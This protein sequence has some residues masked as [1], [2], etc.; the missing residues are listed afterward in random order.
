MR[1][2]VYPHT[3]EVGGSQLN[4]IELAEAVR[5]LG[6]EVMLV[7]DPGP[8]VERVKAAG[9]EHVELDTARRRPDPATV[10]L[11]R[12]LVA[13]RGID[14]VHGYEWP[15][16]LEAY[17]ATFGRS[18]AAAVCTVMSSGV[19]PFLPRELPLIVGTEE[20]RAREAARRDDVRLIEPPVDVVANAP[21]HPSEEFRKRFGLGDDRLDI[22]VVCRLVPEL[23]LEG[24]LTAVEVVGRL[25]AELPVRL[26]VVGDGAARDQ[27]ESRAAEANAR[28]GERVVVLTGELF[29]PRP[30][31]ASGAVAIGMGG[32]A[33]R[34]LAFGCPLVVQGEAGFF[35]LLTPETVD[36]F[37][38]GGWYGLGNGPA[39][40]ARRLEEALRPLLTDAK[41]RAELGAFGRSLVVERFSLERAARVQEGIYRDALDRAGSRASLRSAAASSAA[42]FGYKVRRKYARA[43]GRAPA[44]DFN[45]V[46]KNAVAKNA[47]AKNVAGKNAVGK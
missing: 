38:T 44:D 39:E 17:F 2:L 35:E 16:G 9:L 33:L 37:L 21:G 8:L 3:M 32:S 40:G 4:A 27:V 34:A 47:V 31:Y 41:L 29:D 46:A 13:E 15:P 36:R 7:S 28:A 12:R 42:V 18:P 20:L 30:A 45:A 6:H 5:D 14:V 23:K 24:L 10:R 22:V 1:I 43:R 11:L 26:V 19:A 25:A